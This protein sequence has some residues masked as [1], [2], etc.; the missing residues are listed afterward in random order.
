MCLVLQLASFPS[1]AFSQ[2]ACNDRAV[3]CSRLPV[4]AALPLRAECWGRVT[5]GR[6]ARRGYQAQLEEP[7]VMDAV[8][9]LFGLSFQ[10]DDIH[11]HVI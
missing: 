11:V 7:F 10:Y 8:E 1:V 9:I 2:H 4:L 5:P 6:A 3:C